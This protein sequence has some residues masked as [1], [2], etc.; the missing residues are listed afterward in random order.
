MWGRLPKNSQ[1]NK[2]P[3]MAF[4]WERVT[5]VQQASWNRNPAEHVEQ[6]SANR[7][8]GQRT[9]PEHAVGNANRAHHSS[10]ILT[11]STR[12]IILSN[13]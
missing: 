4:G 12:L 5:L 3:T 11:H 1:A 6:S 8:Q 2:Q 9:G 10:P 7:R 13:Y